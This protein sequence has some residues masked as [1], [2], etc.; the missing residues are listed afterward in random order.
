MKC[1]CKHKCS[2]CGDKFRLTEYEDPGIKC[3]E[4]SNEANRAAK[5][6]YKKQKKKDRIIGF[7]MEG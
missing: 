3:P 5:K 6:E 1:N 2:N 7:K 4:C